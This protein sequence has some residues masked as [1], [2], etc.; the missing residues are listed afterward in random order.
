MAKKESRQRVQASDDSL[1]G[2]HHSVADIASG[3]RVES[4]PGFPACCCIG[5]VEAADRAFR[6]ILFREV[7]RRD[8]HATVPHIL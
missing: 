1:A 7:R 8:S 4:Y 5:R 3:H 6:I 2:S